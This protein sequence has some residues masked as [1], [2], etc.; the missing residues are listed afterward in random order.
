MNALLVYMIKVAVYLAGFYLVYRLLLSRDTMYGRN[1]SFIL[2]SVISALILPFA[3]IETA[4]PINIPVFS[5]V[6]SDIF[7]TDAS[8]Q[9]SSSILGLTGISGYQLLFL[10]YLTGVIISGLKLIIDFAELFILIGHQ[11][12]RGSRIIKFHG[13]NTAGFSAFGHIFVSERLTSDEADEIIR[14]EQNHLN[15]HHS[16]DIVIMEIVRAFQW[17]NPFIHL[18]TRSLRAVHEYQADKEC[19]TKGISVN[20]YQKLLFNQVFKSKVF[21]ITNSFSNPSLIKK[22]MIMMTKRRSRALANL[23]LLM[24]LPV[25]AAVMIFISSCKQSNKPAENV[26]EIA[27]P[28]PPPPPPPTVAETDSD[29][30]FV[31]VDVMPEFKGGDVALMKYIAQN[32]KYPEP[33]KTKGI[34]GKVIVRFAVETD[35]SIDKVTVLKGV[36]PELDQEAL[37]VVSSLPAF[38]KPGVKD[39]KNV[40]V[41]Y[42][43]PINF[44]LN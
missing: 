25:I 3:A 12:T 18:F 42:M 35:G 6:L 7:I 11:K 19:I 22:R 28:P 27:P 40:A 9:S 15:H 41:W 2:L 34:Q 23:K 36:D 21:T 5:R 26:T 37:R 38:E 30:P 1:R 31:E 29:A 4:K 14:H 39:G 20:N 32:T 24:V 10:I 17:F 13:L 44:T 33:A 8:N 16:A 43:I